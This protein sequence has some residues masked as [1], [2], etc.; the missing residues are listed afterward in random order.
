MTPE[1][2]S[3]TIHVPMKLPGD[4]HAP[5]SGADAVAATAVTASRS[6][7]FGIAISR[8]MGT[9]VVTV[10]GELDVTAARHLGGL[11][12]DIIDGEG[13]LG[14]LVDLQDASGAAADGGASMFAA[15][16]ELASKRGASLR[17]YNPPDVLYEAL[18]LT[19]LGRLA[20]TTPDGGRPSPSEPF[21]R[22]AAPGVEPP[23]W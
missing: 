13:N 22:T 16:A 18:V 11:L 19:G 17:L 3:T 20:H 10:H 7:H 9:V 6:A 23:N 5:T 15:T 8:S 14:V 4:P 12:A 2:L 1:H 21:G